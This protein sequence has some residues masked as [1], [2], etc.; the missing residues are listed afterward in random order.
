MKKYLLFTSILLAGCAT[1][2]QDCDL[3]A[4][5]PGF[6][7]KL[8]CATSGGYRQKIDAQEQQ[9]LQS[10]RDNNIA[11]QNLEITQ[12]REQT[13]NQQLSD[14]QA[15]LA[16]LRSDLAQTLKRLQSGK[17]KNKQSQQEIKQL[18]A[19]QQ[20]SLHATSPSELA[21]IEKKVAEAKHKVEALEQ[22]NALR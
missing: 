16:A 8:N 1:T 2:P 17:V 14:E 13:T 5:D 18:Q 9:I 20:Q 6:L 7:T 21:A 19:L 12:K 4:Q 22:A 3:N 11:K 15:R 10:Q